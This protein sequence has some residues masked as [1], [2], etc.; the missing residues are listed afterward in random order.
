MKWWLRVCDGVNEYLAYTF[1]GTD[2]HAVYPHS[3]VNGWYKAYDLCDG[4]R[5]IYIQKRFVVTMYPA[6]ADE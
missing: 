1:T 2:D 4:D 5:F 6:E 3:D